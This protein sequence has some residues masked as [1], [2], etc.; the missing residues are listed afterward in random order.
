MRQLALGLGAAHQRGVMHRDL[1]PANVL[2]TEDGEARITDFGV[3]RS[4]GSTGIT[5]S[6]VIIGTPEY[7]S[8]EQA[9]ADPVDGRSDLYALG[10][11][12]FEMLTGTLPFRGGTP[13]EMLAQ[14]IVRDP[15]SPSTIK[16]D[17]PNFAVR[18]C[19]RLLELKPSRRFQSAEDVIRAID[20]KRVLKVVRPRRALVVTGIVIA[21]VAAA[22]ALFEWRRTVNSDATVATPV[23]VPLLDV[24]TMPALADGADADLAAGIRQVATAELLDAAGVRGSDARRVDR[25]LSELGYDAGA[26][27]RQRARVG[28]TLG[29]KQL[30]EID[31]VRDPSG[32]YSARY[33]VWTP[34][35]TAPVWTETTPPGTAAELPRRLQTMQQHLATQLGSTT[36]SAT[37]PDDAS[38]RAI[39]RLH[40]AGKP[41]TTADALALARRNPEP[42]L[43]WS[44]EESLDRADRAAEATTVARQAKDALSNADGRD[45]ERARAYADLLLGDYAS[46]APALQRLI[47]ATPTDHPARLL[48]ARAE[49]ETGQFD[50]ARQTLDAV[51]AEDSRNIDAWFLLGKF[52]IMQGDANLAVGDYLTRARILAN[53][54]DDARMQADVTNAIGIGYRHL[55]KSTAAAK[56]FEAASEQRGALGDKRGQGV[57]LRNLATVLATQGD[58]HGA[59]NALNQARAVLTPLGDPT[60]LADL[61]NDVGVFQEERGEFRRAL[62]AYREA[63]T[64]RQTQGDQRS[65]GESQINVGYIYYQ[66]GE[67]DNAEAYWQQAAATYSRIDDRVGI[68]HA[69]QVRALGHMARGRFTDARQLLEQSLHEAEAMQMAEERSTSLAALAELDAIAGDPGHALANAQAA[70]EIFRAREDDRGRVEMKLLASAILIDVGDWD[71]AEAAL[72]NL[73][74]DDVASRE[75]AAILVWRHGQIALGRGDA[76]RAASIAADAIKAAQTAHSYATELS[77]RLLRVRALAAANKPKE[78]IAELA[79]T[80]AELAKYASVPLRLQ[81]AEAAL[82]ASGAAAL[83]D[84]RSVSADLARLPAYARAFEIHALADAAL[85]K[86]ADPNERE[87]RVAAHAA[88]TALAKNT[89]PAQQDALAKLG[90]TYGVIATELPSG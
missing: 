37:W 27:R 51:V 55:G 29:V 26:A 33:A 41:D 12:F 10:L 65:I 67:F 73:S 6:G 76:M 56:E 81:L 19:A 39:G 4:A 64:F 18:L 31:L 77:A 80:R 78:S 32:N 47:K 22:G 44:I 14:R 13:A 59:E 43:W 66:V 50:V 42:R 70:A 74:A 5:V 20:T 88:F 86:K 83:P 36:K 63:L 62:D 9:R 30:L 57:S 34:S 75:Q 11:I 28:E 72:E 46:A 3:A 52:T 23:V 35:G 58:V 7:L 69:D 61:A 40:L 38:I 53:R 48:Y 8:P 82:Q 84:Y 21:F 17:L 85:K 16:N 89:P 45:A 87:A 71:G 24:A 15:P 90:A 2:I 1:K 79:A 25:A 49:A 54:L 68:V 60:A